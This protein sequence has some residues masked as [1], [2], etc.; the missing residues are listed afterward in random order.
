MATGRVDVPD[1]MQPGGR[2]WRIATAVLALLVAVVSLLP[3]RGTPGVEIAD[4]GEVLATLGHGVAY[5]VLAASAVLSQRDPRT[6]L[7]WTVVVAY[8]ALLEIAQ[9]A[10]GLRSFQLTDIAANAL[11][12]LVGVLVAGAWRRRARAS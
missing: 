12:A 6:L 7:T 2:A 5:A 4:L 9:G 1:A 8:G 3:P 10:L 11:G